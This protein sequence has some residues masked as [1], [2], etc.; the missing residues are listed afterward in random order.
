MDT[1]NLECFDLRLN[2]AISAL[3]EEFPCSFFITQQLL[4]LVFD[5]LEV[6]RVPGF[7][8]ISRLFVTMHHFTDLFFLKLRIQRS[9]VLFIILSI[10]LTKY[11]LSLPWGKAKDSNLELIRPFPPRDCSIFTGEL[12]R[13]SV[14]DVRHVECRGFFF[15][16]LG[17]LLNLFAVLLCT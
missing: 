12:L 10:V 3:H 2:I 11:Y 6:R 4:S 13:K 16:H 8:D 15:S 9:L 7:G 17:I 14:A 1:S 5:G